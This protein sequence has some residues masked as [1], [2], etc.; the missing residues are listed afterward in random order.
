MKFIRLPTVLGIIGIS[1][2]KLYADIKN[3][4][5]PPPI[6]LGA[7]AVGWLDTEVDDWI[8]SRVQA[9]RIAH[10]SPAPQEAAA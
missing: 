1:R 3:G 10:Q 2:S 4:D 8:N 7:R 6:S 5:F 9:T